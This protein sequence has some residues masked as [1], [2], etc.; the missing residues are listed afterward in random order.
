ML[1]R[2]ILL[3]ALI[4]S[5][6]VLCVDCSNARADETARVDAGQLCAVKAA[7][8]RGRWSPQ[9][10]QGVAKALN[11]TRD[12]VLF[13]AIAVYESDLRE[14]SFVTRPRG[15]Y[16]I[17]L[18]GVRCVTRTH[19]EDTQDLCLNGAARGLTFKKLLDAPTNIRAAERVFYE[20][21][22][23]SLR[24]YSG[25]TKE[26]GYSARIAVLVAALGG[27]LRIPRGEHGAKWKRIRDI[28]MLIVNAL[29]TEG[30][31]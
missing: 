27:E 12:P 9:M 8:R 2:E 17:G 5:P 15:V 20:T 19:E 16:D 1:A 28:A 26:R 24:G 22:K 29:K 21:H 14:K 18:M 13:A 6:G 10:C 23:G 7:M 25:S 11:E 3:V 4:L 30:N 31:T